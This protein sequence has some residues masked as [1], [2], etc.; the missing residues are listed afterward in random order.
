MQWALADYYVLLDGQCAC[1]F[2]EITSTITIITTTT[3][4]TAIIIITWAATGD[5]HGKPQTINY[6]IKSICLPSIRIWCKVVI[7]VIFI[8]KS[9]FDRLL[10]SAV[11]CL[12]VR[13]TWQIGVWIKFSMSYMNM[14]AH[15]C[16]LDSIEILF[17]MK[18]EEEMDF[19]LGCWCLTV[20][21]TKNLSYLVNEPNR[22]SFGPNR[23]KSLNVNEFI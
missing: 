9:V 21:M 12:S 5:E 22:I 19:C 11:A 16:R 13:M 3:S 1:A 7:P 2:S 20:A 18:Y 14:T 15:I 17:A 23:E 4:S 10:W 8:C 6:F